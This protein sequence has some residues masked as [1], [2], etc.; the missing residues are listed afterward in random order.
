MRQQEEAETYWVWL[1]LLKPQSSPLVTYFL[2]QNHTYSNNKATPLNS[3]V[4]VSLRPHSFKLS[5]TVWGFRPEAQVSGSPQMYEAWRSVSDTEA[6]ES[7]P[8]PPTWESDIRL[9]RQKGRLETLDRGS[10]GASR[11]DWDGESQ[12][13]GS[14]QV[15]E[16][17]NLQVS[18][19]EAPSIQTGLVR[20]GFWGNS[21]LWFLKL[22]GRRTGQEH[23]ESGLCPLFRSHGLI[24]CHVTECVGFWVVN[25]PVWQPLLSPC[26]LHSLH[27]QDCIACP[28]TWWDW[29]RLFRTPVS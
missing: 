19:Q 8:L 10:V 24:C 26:R 12:G 2:P 28:V 5:L 23:L 25:C 29:E 18:V 22:K 7:S 6:V 1:E 15:G 17:L 20:E 14:P 9:E 3:A 4:P 16:C 21:V 13:E 27:P 11:W